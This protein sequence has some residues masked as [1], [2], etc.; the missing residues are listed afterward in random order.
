V[1]AR[2]KQFNISQLPV[3][4]NGGRYM[5]MVTEVDLLNHLLSSDH[6]QDASDTIE[7]IVDRDSAEVVGP[8]TPLTVLSEIFRH[9]RVAVVCEDDKVTGIV[10]KIDLIEYLAGKPS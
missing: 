8:E 1:I 10:S 3:V 6:K 4:E 2:M 9:G 5:G 7:K